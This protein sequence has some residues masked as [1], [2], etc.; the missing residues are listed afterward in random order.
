MKITGV[1]R[2]EL[3]VG[4]TPRTEPHMR[5]GITNFSLIEVCRVTTDTGVVGWGE[6][7]AMHNWD[8]DMAAV[9][10][11][12]I[13]RNPAELLWR[14]ELGSGL[15]QAMFDLTGK[16]LGV[17]VHRLIGRQARAW[18]PLAWWCYDMPPEDWAAEAEDAIA[19]GFT[20]F[21]LKPR[22]WFDL[23]AQIEAISAATP[24]H[25]S[26]DLDF[27]GFLLDAGF[28]QQVLAELEAFPKIHMFETPIPQRDVAG[29]ATL[30]A[31]SRRAIALHF[32]EPDFLT[33][34]REHV[35]DGFAGH[36]E[37][38]AATLHYAALAHAANLPFFVQ[39]VGTGI[40]TAFAAHLA[41]ALPA[42]RWPA[43]TALNVYADDLI[44]E[45]LDIQ[46]GYVRVPEAP[47]LGIEVDEQALENLRRD[48]AGPKPLPRAIYTVRWPYGRTAE[49][50][51]V[52]AYERDFTVGNQPVFERGVT[53]T[54]R[55]DDGSVEFDNR[56]RAVASAGIP[57]PSL[58]IPSF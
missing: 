33:A 36:G 1:E 56:Y 30:R 34:M 41:A 44:R 26:F 2:I 17:P 38:V 4:F 37:G 40:T 19:A 5:R 55:E 13:G 47:G 58:P 52:R 32:E 21:K 25:A 24:D 50:V 15:Q 29:N 35:C 27:N 16:A 8:R 53:L 7:R 57:P 20:A 51:S 46:R 49:Y 48:A 12:V 31:K 22:P 54:A 3:D 43:V 18:V 11:G 42:A 14:D 23:T 10:A 45:P 9:D 28:A 6:S 39:L